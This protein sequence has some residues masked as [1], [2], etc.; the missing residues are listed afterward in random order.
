MNPNLVTAPLLESQAPLDPLEL[1]SQWLADAEQLG[2]PEPNAMTLATATPEGVP[3]ARVVL[4]RGVDRRGFVF[5]T[6]YQSRK[7]DELARNPRAALVFFWSPPP[8]QV[9][10]EGTVEVVTPA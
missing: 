5:F 6:N 3:S 2:L 10:V 7:G 9:R 8:R 1:F 4:L